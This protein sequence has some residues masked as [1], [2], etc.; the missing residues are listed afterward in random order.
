MINA[1]K[2]RFLKVKA[3]TFG[4]LP[5]G[6]PGHPLGGEAFIFWDEILVNPP[7]YELIEAR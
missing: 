2:A 6:H 4:P 1:V 3:K 7:I 5:E